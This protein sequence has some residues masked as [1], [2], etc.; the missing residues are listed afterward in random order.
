MESGSSTTEP[1]TPRLLD[2]L[3]WF[4][5]RTADLA[6]DYLRPARFRPVSIARTVRD[7]AADPA[8]AFRFFVPGAEASVAWAEEANKLEI[9]L[10]VSQS[11]LVLGLP[12][13]PPVPLP[14]YVQRAYAGSSF[15]A[16]WLVEGLGNDWTDVAW[17]D[18]ARPPRGLLGGGDAQDVVEESLLMLH[19]GLG[20]AVGRRVFRRLRDDAGEEDLQGAAAQ[21][22]TLCESNARRGYTGAALESLGLAARMFYPWC[23]TGLGEALERI[24]D[25]ADFFWHGV[26]RAVY[27]LPASFLPCGH[28]TW[29]N[30]RMIAAEV[31]AGRPRL[32]AIAGL[33]WAV[34]LVNQR[35]PQVM[36]DFVDRHGG[37]LTTG[38]A[39][40]NGVASAVV[41]RQATTPDAPFTG[42]FCGYRHPGTSWQAIVAGPCRSALDT[43]YPR[44]AAAG[45]LWEVF[46]YH[47]PSYWS[48]IPGNV[49]AAGT[50]DGV[51]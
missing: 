8:G 1:A 29:R 43:L 46:R 5:R 23:V 21:A 10:L 31:P 18:L 16:L 38:G 30:L 49:G 28:N 34:T 20:L 50:P 42:A 35:H 33:A 48:R 9:Y 2:R 14:P 12:V 24:G 44:L 32:N 6:Y 39:W 37:D 25:Y 36:A 40:S 3:A 22:V 4:R 51:E 19:A 11:A 17:D 26:G 47:P 15:R 27:F 13:R 45:R 41:M 7:L